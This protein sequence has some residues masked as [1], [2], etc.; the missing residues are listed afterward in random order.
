MNIPPQLIKEISNYVQG[1]KSI[2]LREFKQIDRGMT[3]FLPVWD[4]KK[5][6]QYNGYESIKVDEL[7]EFAMSFGLWDNKNINYTK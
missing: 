5:V 4:V 2:L 1:S 3:G 6:F 7:E